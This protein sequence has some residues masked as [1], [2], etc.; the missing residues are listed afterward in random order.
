MSRAR[1]E[2]VALVAVCILLATISWRFIEKPFREEPHR[3]GAYSTLLAG[4]AVMISASV[5]AVVF[6]PLIENVWKYPSRAT[7][8]LSYAIKMEKSHLRLGTCFLTSGSLLDYGF[9]LQ[10][11]CLAV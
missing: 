1:F 10:D 4:G 2:K 9:R 7:E 3:L 8:V 11:Y 5:T 6:S